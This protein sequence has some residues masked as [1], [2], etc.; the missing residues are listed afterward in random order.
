MKKITPAD[1]I[2]LALKMLANPTDAER[3]LYW[4]LAINRVFFKKQCII[5]GFI[6]DAY[7]PREKIAIECDGKQHY[8]NY[9]YDCNRDKILK[10]VGIKTV[11]IRNH[12]IEDD[13]KDLLSVLLRPI[14]Y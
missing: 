3:L 10:G 6:V 11:R 4:Q 12:Q 13:P 7:L 5:K 9:E 14:I 2:K 1:K 8:H